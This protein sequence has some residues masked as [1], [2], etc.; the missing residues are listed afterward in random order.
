M[1]DFVENTEEKNKTK[2]EKN[3]F[4]FM[5]KENWSQEKRI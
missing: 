3:L 5:L 2:T 1:A 4:F